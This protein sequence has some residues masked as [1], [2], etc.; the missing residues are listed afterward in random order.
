MSE[1]QS[2]Y[3]LVGR[4]SGS[5]CMFFTVTDE[6]SWQPSPTPRRSFEVGPRSSYPARRYGVSFLRNC[7]SPNAPST[8]TLMFT[9]ANRLE[10][11]FSSNPTRDALHL[12][13]AGEVDK[14]A[15]FFDVIAEFLLN[16]LAPVPF[17][18]IPEIARNP[19]QIL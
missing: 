10:G 11:V 6:V 18:F 14:P 2:L 7:T 5:S 16:E 3:S 9:A 8:G 4:C 17:Q 1:S 13:G 12:K 15:F 19:V